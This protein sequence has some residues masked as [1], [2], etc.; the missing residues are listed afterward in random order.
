MFRGAAI[1]LL[2]AGSFLSAVAGQAPPVTTG[3]GTALQVLE[4]IAGDA[5]VQVADQTQPLQD[6][7]DQS[8]DLVGLTVHESADSFNFTLKVAGLDQAPEAPAADDGVYYINFR[9]NDQDY[10]I[11]MYRAL[12]DIAYYWGFLLK[13]DPSGNPNFQRE[14]PVSADSAS[15]TISTTIDRSDIQDGQGAAPFPGRMLTGFWAETHLRTNQEQF[16]IISGVQPSK[17]W[18]ASDRMPDGGNGTTDFPIALGIAQSGHARLWSPDPIRASNGE[19][20]TFLFNVS[21]QNTGSEDELFQLVANNV[22]SDWTLTLPATFIRI[23]AGQTVALPVLVSTPFAHVHGTLKTFDLELIGQTDPNSIGR[24]QL[25]I[26]YFLVPQP[27]GHHPFLYFHSLRFGSQSPLFDA[28]ELGFSGNGGLTYMNTLDK[29]TEDSGVAVAA[30]YAGFYCSPIC[31]PHWQWYIYLQPSLQMGLDFDTKGK[32]DLKVPVVARVPIP[33]LVL[34]GV[35]VHDA[36]DEAAGAWKE[37]VVASL[38]DSAPAD[39]QPNAVHEY[40]WTLSPTKQSDLL[41]YAKRAYL[42]LVLNATTIKPSSFTGAESPQLAPGGHMTL[43]LIEYR[44]PVTQAFTSVGAVRLEPQGD[45]ER[46]V[47]PGK[48]A[49]FTARVVNDLPEAHTFHL[50]LTGVHTDWSKILGGDEVT[51]ASRGTAEVHVSVTVPAEE[52]TS[53][54]TVPHVADL[55]L[56]AQDRGNPELRAL[57]RIAAVVDTKAEHADDA[58]LVA[59]YDTAPARKSPGL[60]MPVLAMAVVALALAQDRR[61]ADR[62]K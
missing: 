31:Q 45:R 46:A 33:Q 55:V 48:T 7:H 29:D 15:A 28:I 39:I 13:Y 18:D 23:P 51:V 21:G 36:Y 47:N 2:V 56:T 24:A 17:E 61:R 3:T 54:P 52:A 26:R 25:G 35:L 41:P 34:G 27:A 40:A 43:P 4:D 9:H 8:L 30:I 38:N 1:F 6:A 60:E 5:R 12:G 37:T 32:I 20:S 11:A 62:L 16:L 19:Q 22:P 10:R 49:V 50:N 59:T 44:D 42:T 57:L 14:V 58:A 53:D